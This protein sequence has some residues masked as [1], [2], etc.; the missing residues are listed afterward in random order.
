[1]DKLIQNRNIENYVPHVSVEFSIP[2]RSW[3]HRPKILRDCYTQWNITSTTKRDAILIHATTW[4]DP[5]NTTLNEISQT[6][7]DKYFKIPLI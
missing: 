1:M 7:K 5:E 4:M 2:G 3:N 6:R